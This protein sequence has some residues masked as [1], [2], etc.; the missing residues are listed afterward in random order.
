MEFKIFDLGLVDFKYA[1]NFQKEIFIGVKS[2]SLKSAIILCR[3]YPVITLGRLAKNEHILASLE[4]LK[5]KG[6]PVYSIER[7]GDVTY[8]GPGQLIVYPIL[9]LAYFKKDIHWFL[10]QL[11]KI[12][13]DF[14]A[15][16]GI[17]ALTYEGKTGVWI[18]QQKI[19]SIGIAIK[20]WITFHGLSINIKRND[21]AGFRMIKP[22]G[23]DIE[24]ASLETLL[25]RNIIIDELKDTFINQF[26]ES[27]LIRRE[28]N[29]ESALAAIK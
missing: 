25:K 20:N 13:I 1:W 26:Q 27:F 18:A 22:C 28:I 16:F 5:A 15:D 23:M 8:H 4:V 2:G 11:E 3:H 12:I 17:K 9:N 29:D 6:I 21:L 19:A 14:L 24:M 10:R 7:A